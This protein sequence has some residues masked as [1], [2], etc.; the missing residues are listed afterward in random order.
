MTVRKKGHDGIFTKN[1]LGFLEKIQK[2]TKPIKI[3]VLPHSSN[4]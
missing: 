2:V 4:G 3:L 1:I